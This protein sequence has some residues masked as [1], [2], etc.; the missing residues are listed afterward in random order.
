M[1]DLL[2]LAVKNLGDTLRLAFEH[3]PTD[4]A[5]VVFDDEHELTKLLVEA[6]RVVL[7]SAEF[8]RVADTTGEA[9]RERFKQMPAGA[10]VVLVQTTNFRLNEFR[11]RLEIFA[12]NLKTIEHSHLNR[13]SESQWQTY[14]ESLAYNPTYLRS[15]GHALKERLGRCK[16]VTVECGDHR[17]V[18]DTPMEEA[19]LNVGDYAGM[20][21]VGGTFPI[22]EVFTESQDLGKANGE[23]LIYGLAGADHMVQIHEPFLATVKEGIIDA[24]AGSPQIF[25]DTIALI[26]AQERSLVREIGFGLNPAM[27]RT[28]VVNDITAYER[29]TGL[30]LSLG[31]K[32]GIYKKPGLEPGKTRYHVDVFVAADRILIDDEVIFEN[33]VYTV[34]G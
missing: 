25:Q 24:P 1:S 7:P 10:L 31:E 34:G 19:K 23:L 28:R 4:P 9:I 16:R 29:M 30:H 2:T 27:D 5:L 33:G 32:H 8:L 11:F 12:C 14:I 6:Y 22:G 26:R 15:L 20:K 17:L 18:F 3:Q 13:Q 21:N